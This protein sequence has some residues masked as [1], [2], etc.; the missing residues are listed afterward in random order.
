MA[1]NTNVARAKARAHNIKRKLFLRRTA[2]DEPAKLKIY[3]GSVFRGELESNWNLELNQ[4]TEHATGERYFILFI[5]DLDGE[6]LGTLKAMTKVR[7]NSV[8]YKFLSK[9]SFL[10]AIPSYV[11]R[12]QPL[13]ER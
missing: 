12:V 3:E 13:T 8:E 11:F 10:T 9:P 1:F 7:V 4:R 5:D 6:L 2:T